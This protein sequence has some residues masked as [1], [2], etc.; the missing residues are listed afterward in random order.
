MANMAR[1]D[2][3]KRTVIVDRVKLLEQLAA[4]K[5]KHV[6][7]YHEAVAGY[8]EMAKEKLQR[9][10]EK[11]KVSLEDNVKKGLEKIDGFDPE[12]DSYGVTTLID[13][14]YVDLPIPKNYE[15][16]YDAAIDMVNWDTRA[17][18]ELTHAE[19]QC[20]VRDVWDWTSDFFGVTSI[21]NTKAK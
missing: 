12:N 15:D 2:Q 9:A 3:Q 16:E 10:Y 17:E 21:Y 1:Q 20:F 6:R 14:V 7:E 5:E 4:N 11:A 19:F 13:A 8:K 18:L